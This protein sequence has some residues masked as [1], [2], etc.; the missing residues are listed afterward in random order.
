MLSNGRQQNLH[1][2]QHTPGLS[3]ASPSTSVSSLSP[4]EVS[5]CAEVDRLSED[6]CLEN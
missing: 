4:Y 2:L 6:L 1:L 5:S 3:E